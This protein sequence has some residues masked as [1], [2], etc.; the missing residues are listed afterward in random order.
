VHSEAFYRKTCRDKTRES[1]VESTTMT[2]NQHL[3]EKEMPD[4][5][6]FNTEKAC[7]QKE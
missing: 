7:D 5:A 2:M 3:R 6:E 4:N 1:W